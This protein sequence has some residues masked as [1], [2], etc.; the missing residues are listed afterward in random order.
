MITVQIYRYCPYCTACVVLRTTHR[1]V[2]GRRAP[3]TYNP[4]PIMHMTKLFS[5]LYFVSS[6]ATFLPMA[7]ARP[8]RRK[9]PGNNDNVDLSGAEREDFVNLPPRRVL[10]PRKAR[11][12]AA[13][14]IKKFYKSIQ[15]APKVAVLEKGKIKEKRMKKNNRKEK[16]PEISAFSIP[17]VSAASSLHGIRTKRAWRSPSGGLGAEPPATILR[18]SRPGVGGGAPRP[19][20]PPGYG[21]SQ[22]ADYVSILARHHP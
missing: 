1:Q 5:F 22:F 11:T 6:S 13:A 12:V 2:C 3:F 7:P 18:R 15:H 10:P 4:Y 14:S 17:V 8:R 19:P 9:K 16:S 21:I 20:P